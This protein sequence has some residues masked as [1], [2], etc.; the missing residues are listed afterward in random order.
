N[1]SYIDM[2]RIFGIASE[3]EVDG[4]HT[5][6]GFMNENSTFAK[7][8]EEEGMTFV[9]PSGSVMEQMGDKITARNVMERVGVPIAKGTTEAIPTLEEAMEIAKKIGY[10]VML[11]ASAGEIGR[12][13]CR[14]R[15]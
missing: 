11:K 2:D 13:S 6:Y 1:E 10:P 3:H 9:G 12:A 7:K 14:E 4:I 5:G 15:V 8:C